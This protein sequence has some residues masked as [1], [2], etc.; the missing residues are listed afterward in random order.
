MDIER[1]VIDN[2]G[3]I[4]HIAT[5]YYE[6][7]QDAEDLAGETIYRILC[8]CKRFDPSRSFKPW[9]LTIMEN[10]FKQQ[11]NRRKRILFTHDE[12]L[13][14]RPGTDRADSLAVFAK[15]MSIVHQTARKT[16][17]IESVLLY[18]KGYTYEEIA[19]IV[20]IPI[21]TVKSRVS[22]GRKILREA[23]R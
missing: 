22:I 23:F 10:T 21:G 19:R 11:Y 7:A 16:I 13:V 18:A 14:S 8:N 1:L 20:G 5:R 9:A 6:D 2:A 12:G 4:R 3:W 15:T 17:N